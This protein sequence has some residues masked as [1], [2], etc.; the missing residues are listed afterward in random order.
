M[1]IGS[2]GRTHIPASQS[3][4]GLEG[5]LVL[6]AAGATRPGWQYIEHVHTH[7][8]TPQPRLP[9]RTS[10]GPSQTRGQRAAVEAAG[11]GDWG[12]GNTTRP[13]IAFHKFTAVSIHCDT[14]SGGRAV[15]RA[16]H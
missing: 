5:L 11:V 13:I 7:P 12:G 4:K 10:P 14:D 6:P 2:F 15:A 16:L 3:L 8:P 1:S 9:A